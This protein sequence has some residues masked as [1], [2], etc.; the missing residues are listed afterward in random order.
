MLPESMVQSKGQAGIQTGTGEIIDVLSAWLYSDLLPGLHTDPLPVYPSPLPPIA[1][2]SLL[3]VSSPASHAAETLCLLTTQV[4]K[5]TDLKLPVGFPH[6][7]S[8]SLS[9]FHMD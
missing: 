2:P 9:E 5:A 3:L 4:F 7:S 1:F 8:S 6:H